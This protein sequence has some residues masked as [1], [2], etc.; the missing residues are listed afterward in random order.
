MSRVLQ[1][2][3]EEEGGG[4]G[5][6]RVLQRG[7]GGYDPRP[8]FWLVMGAYFWL[9][10]NSVFFHKFTSH[11]RRLFAFHTLHRLRSWWFNFS[12]IFTL[13]NSTE[14]GSY[15]GYTSHTNFCLRACKSFITLG[16]YHSVFF[17]TG[18]LQDKYR[19]KFILW[20][21]RYHTVQARRQNWENRG[22]SK[23]LA[24]QDEVHTADGRNLTRNVINTVLKYNC[25][26]HSL[27]HRFNISSSYSDE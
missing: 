6:E 11:V 16:E 7:G 1:R 24:K 22:N 25:Y 12:G 3:V 13:E 5:V 21:K 4:G 23:C 2:G 17:R 9:F 10:L 14:A 19:W 27:R 18:L 15:A 8:H 20:V 26:A